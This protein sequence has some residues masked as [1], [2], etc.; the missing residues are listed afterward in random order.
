MDRK[1][2][3]IIALAV[4][5]AFI[6]G[7]VFSA[8]YGIAYADTLQDQLNKANQKKTEAQEKLN[9]V[10]AE[11]EKS[12][13]TLDA[14]EK[15][16][17]ALQNSIND[18]NEKIN[19]TDK[20]LKA[21]EQ[22]LQDATE[23]AE[24][25]YEYFKERFRIVCEEGPVTYLELLFSAKN[26]CDFVD[27]I[28]IAKEITESDK[29]IFDEMEAIRAEVE[30]SRNQILE[31]KNAQVE[32]KNSLVEKQSQV[33]AKKREREQFI[34]N[35]EKD[36]KAYQKIIDQ[37]EQAMQALKNRIA[38]SLSSSSGGAK[39]VGGEFMWPSNCTIITSHFSPRRKNPVTGV[40]KRHTGVDIG[41]AYGTPIFAANG[42]RVTLAGWNS[43][44]GNCVIIDHG[45][46]KA[47]LYA[48]M[49]SIG[50]SNGQAV[51]KGQ[52]IGR[53][54]STGNST[55]PHI[56]FE[57]LINGTAVDPMQYF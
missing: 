7:L 5:I 28:E 33:S 46:G 40:Y 52:T 13:A 11:R 3:R 19:E 17:I 55:G 30:N 51:T 26:F 57:I 21:E 12:L 41:A 20:E 10:N 8:V 50:V 25:K 44:Y 54:G 49:S 35:L 9:K 36:A 39:Y 48:H 38:S 1:A 22:K 18:I 45:G 4:S 43:G 34:K 47:T 24:K 2:V 29:K 32:S 15:E 31:L 23:R 42:G 53:V 14:F 27:K 56:H 16:F 6:A 37:E